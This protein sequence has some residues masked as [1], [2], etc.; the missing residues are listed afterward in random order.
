[1]AAT[2]GGGPLA[3]AMKTLHAGDQRKATEIMLEA[4]REAK[5]RHG[6]TSPELAASLFQLAQFCVA[7]GQYKQAAEAAGK[8][9]Q[10]HVPGDEGRKQR[11]TYLRSQSELLQRAGDLE[12][13]ERVLRTALA[14][15]RALYGPDHV[16]YARGL[17]PLAEVVW[18]RGQT[19]EAAALIEEAVAILGRAGDAHDAS[20]LVLR[21]F[22]L[23]SLDSP[24]PA[25]GDLDG[26]PAE[27][28]DELVDQALHRAKRTEPVLAQAVLNE[29]RDT[30]ALN[31]D[32]NDP[33]L[34]R[35]LAALADAAR[36]AGD[37]EGW[38]EALEASRTLA[39]ARGL[40]EQA[41]QSEQA[42]ALALDESGLTEEA[43]Q[44]YRAAR[45]R[46]EK[47]GKPALLASVLRQYGLF[48]AG[49]DCRAEA[50]PILREAAAAAR[51][52]RDPETIG[53]ALVALGV[54]EQHGGHPD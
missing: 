11:L 23:R 43:E 1:M 35:I 21:A 51:A 19:Q 5:Q 10:V 22:L 47:L 20:A 8:A 38:R 31:L 15:R 52:A 2:A 33:R 16:G 26:M 36:R 42:L 30:I 34:L 25:F 7:I 12:G 6:A 49:H 28:I 27:R 13:A 46:A 9:A 37:K 32:V 41:L 45:A 18:K 24:Q 48:L 40:G 39:E 3:A 44:A 50:E 53:R 17:E 29:L 54:F 4:V 14:E